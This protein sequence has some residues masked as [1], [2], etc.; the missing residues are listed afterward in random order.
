[1]KRL[2]RK[3]GRSN[4]RLI[5]LSLIAAA[6]N[7][8]VT[9]PTLKARFGIHR[10]DPGEDGCYSVADVVKALGR[11][12]DD[13][14]ELSLQTHS[15]WEAGKAKLA[16]LEISEREK[17]LIKKEPMMKFLGGMVQTVYRTIESF[18]LDSEQL[19]NVCHGIE[20]AAES[21]CLAEGHSLMTLSE[22]REA[23]R[24]WP[25]LRSEWELWARL[26]CERYYGQQPTEH[27]EIAG[28]RI[29]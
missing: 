17:I 15:R 29:D 28:G 8:G 24:R 5:R 9:P 13:P 10:I 25:H 1:V 12:G 21:Y 27:S 7:A 3:V 26:N 19:A 22:E 20:T 6:T 2:K 18:G 16:E 11:N 23:R 4:S 14:K